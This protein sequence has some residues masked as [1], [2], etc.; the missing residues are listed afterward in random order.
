MLTEVQTTKSES[1]FYVG[2][3]HVTMNDVNTD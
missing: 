2:M 3:I 1:E